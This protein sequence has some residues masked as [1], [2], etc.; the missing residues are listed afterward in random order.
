MIVSNIKR[1][2]YCYQGSGSMAYH[3]ILLLI[4]FYSDDFEE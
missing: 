1:C 4:M 3:H 2:N